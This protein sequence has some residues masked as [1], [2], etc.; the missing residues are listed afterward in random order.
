MLPTHFTSHHSSIL[1]GAALPSHLA[2][3][4]SL[5]DRAIRY[6]NERESPAMID[7]ALKLGAQLNSACYECNALV[8]AVRANKPWAISTLMMRGAEVPRPPEDGV[9]LLMEVCRDGQFEMA[10]ALIDIAKIS[11]D[12]VDQSGK[13][14]LHHAV[15]ARSEELATLL[16]ERGASQD[17]SASALS[18]TE[19]Q[20]IF[21]H[22]T[23]LHGKAVTPLMIAVANGDEPLT[24]VMLD[25]GANPDSGARSPLIIAACSD[26]RLIFD[27]LLRFGASLEHCQSSS[28]STGLYACIESR[29]PVDYLSKLISQHNF[30]DD[31]GSIHSPLGSAI[32]LN[33]IHTIALLLACGAPVEDYL[34]SDEPLTLWDLIVL[35]REL[36]KFAC[37]LLIA[38]SPRMIDTEDTNHASSLLQEM[39][40]YFDR[41]ARLVSSGIFISILDNAKEGLSKLKPLSPQMTDQ[42]CAFEAAWILSKALPAHTNSSP[43]NNDTDDSESTAP[44]EYWLQQTKKKILAQQGQFAKVCT[45]VLNHGLTQLQLSATLPFFLQCASDCPE[46]QSMSEFIKLRIAENSGVPYSIARLVRNAWINAAKWTQGWQVAPDA[47][48]DSNR[49]LLALAQNLMRKELDEFDGEHTEQVD[50]CITALRDALPLASHPLSQFC[51]NPVAW[52]RKFENRSSLADPDPALPELLQIELGLPHAACEAIVSVWQKALRAARTANWQTPDQLQSLLKQLLAPR[53]SESLLSEGGD[54]IVPASANLLLQNW[55]TQA[56]STRTA[57]GGSRKRPA[58]AEAADAPPRKEARNS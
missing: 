40:K 14:A 10:A 54:K 45:T 15:I 39:V 49:F 47:E 18:A 57:P 58:Q 50:L 43:T 17:A 23:A 27:I 41:P 1:Y 21:G 5:L 2:L 37:Q 12:A 56:M 32:A 6:G 20:D 11:T 29:M 46:A 34:Q 53:I 19:I 22:G 52:L 35:D 42:Q 9:D 28:G 24:Q 25:A 33:D 16:L 36:T 30:S 38:Q 13:T 44:H 51:S 3:A 26:N 48:E 31:D 7:E 8:M 55:R 4:N